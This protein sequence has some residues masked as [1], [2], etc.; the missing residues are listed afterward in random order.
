MVEMEKIEMRC[1]R[2]DRNG[3]EIEMEIVEMEEIEMR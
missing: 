1:W 2:G 3:D